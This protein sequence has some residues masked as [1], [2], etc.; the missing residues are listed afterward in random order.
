MTDDKNDEYGVVNQR[1]QVKGIRN[2]RVI[3]SSIMPKVVSANT[4][5]MAMMIG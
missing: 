5:Q 3:D 4:N 2:L 1:L